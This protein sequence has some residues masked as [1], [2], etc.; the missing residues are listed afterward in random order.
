MAG[1]SF[2]SETADACCQIFFQLG[3]RILGLLST[4]CGQGYEA[5]VGGLTP[6]LV[7]LLFSVTWRPWASNHE[8]SGS[9]Q[10][11]KHQTQS[12]CACNIGKAKEKEI[13]GVFTEAR[14]S[15]VGGGIDTSLGV[16]TKRVG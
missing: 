1:S 7:P 12:Y 14:L 2:E 6:F 9:A 4:R 8:G 5:Q 15:H 11:R 3:S 13:F 16:L 10:R